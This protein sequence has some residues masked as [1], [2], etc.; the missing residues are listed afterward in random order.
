ME[1]WELDPSITWA[2]SSVMGLDTLVDSGALIAHVGDALADGAS[3]EGGFAAIIVDIFA[4]DAL[5]PTL[6]E[7][8]TWEN[9][10][11]KCV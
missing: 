3:V 4:G 9:L 7:D 11:T 8:S 1:G 6:L 10:R 5:L 2:A